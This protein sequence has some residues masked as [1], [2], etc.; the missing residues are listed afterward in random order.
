MHVNESAN[1]MQQ[2]SDVR[3]KHVEHNPSTHLVF[4]MATKFLPLVFG[5]GLAVGVAQVQSQLL[6]GT[7]PS[8]S[9]SPPKHRVSTTA[10]ASPSAPESAASPSAEESPAASPQPKRSRKKAAAEASPSPTLTPVPSPTP[11]KFRLP[12]LFKPKRLPSATPAGVNPAPAPR[13]AN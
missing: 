2:N 13:T 7:P 12:R 1:E 6:T 9:P 4:V 5:V 10:E 8:E 3:G 11:R